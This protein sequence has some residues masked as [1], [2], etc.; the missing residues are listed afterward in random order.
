MKEE[1]DTK[2]SRLP[3]LVAEAS[4]VQKAID[5]NVAIGVDIKQMVDLEQ[6]LTGD[7]GYMSALRMSERRAMQLVERSLAKPF[8]E[9]NML[10]HAEVRG[11]IAERL[12][13]T[14]EIGSTLTLKD[15][16][17]FMQTKKEE[18]IDNLS[19]SLATMKQGRK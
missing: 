4:D 18:M 8:N 15:K 2:I 1:L 16:F 6:V 19:R 17:E 9:K 11:R 5:E 13:L 14:R 3:R 7:V 12:R 10:W